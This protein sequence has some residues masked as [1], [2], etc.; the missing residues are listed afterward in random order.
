[1][2]FFDLEYD[3]LIYEAVVGAK[4]GRATW[5]MNNYET[6]WQPIEGFETLEQFVDRL[7]EVDPTPK[8][9]YMQWMAKMI[10]SNPNA[11]RAED[12]ARTGEDLANFE[13][14]KNKLA[15]KDI[16]QYKSFAELYDAIAPFLVPRELTPEEKKEARDEAKLAKIKEQIITVYTGPEGWIRI[17]T[18]KEA[19]IFLGQNT[20]WCTSARANNMFKSYHDKDSLFVIY[21]KAS[22]KRSQLHI[23]SGQLADESDANLGTN[24]VPEWAKMP[25]HDY[26]IQHNPEL[27][28]DQMILLSR[29]SRTNLAVEPKER[30]FIDLLN[31]YNI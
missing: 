15:V 13:Q 25:I 28:L 5:L 23:E 3:P 10:M 11:N 27:N 18:T 21:D 6:K 19:A 30:E 17:P 12:L 1:M 9:I 26:Y 7:A 14:F 24:A 2:R 4:A 31:K 16:N 22:K 29:W 8:G 20:R